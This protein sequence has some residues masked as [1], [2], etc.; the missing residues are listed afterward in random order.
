MSTDLLTT[1]LY[2]PTHQAT[3]ISRPRLS[4]RMNTAVQR[5]LTLIC[6]PA[7]F[8]KTTAVSEWI[9][10][11]KDAVAWVSLDEGDND[12]ARFLRYM[13]AALQTRSAGIGI[14]VVSLLRSPQPPSMESLLTRLLNDIASQPDELVL[15]LDDY[16]VI[17]AKQVERALTFLLEH[18]PPL[19]HL[20]ITT[21]EDPQLPLSRL[22]ARG[23]MTEI[24]ATDLRF[25]VAEAA[26]FLNTKMG[27]DLAE[28]DIAALEDR[29]EGWI[30]GLQLAAI[31]MQGHQDTAA[32][33][34]SFTGSHRFVMDYLIDEV[35]HRQQESVQNFLLDTSILD[36]LCGP[37]C[38]AVS[39]DSPGSGQ[40]I[41]DYIDGANLFL[42]PL[43]NDRRWYRYHHLFGELLRQRLLVR[44]ATSGGTGADHVAELHIRASRWFELN[45]LEIDALHHAIAAN[46]IA[47]AE[48]LIHGKGVPL[49]V[50]GGAAPVLSWLESLPPH[51]FANS[52]SMCLM[53]AGVLS[54]VGQV[55]RIESKLLAAEAAMQGRAETDG[56]SDLIG[57]IASMRSLVA[58]LSGD[59]HQIETVILQS[60]RALEH[61]DPS[62]TSARAA[63]TWQLGLAHLYQ[64]N[65]A[66]AR[67]AFDE[68]IA[69]SETSGNLHVN[70]LATTCLGNI[71]ETDTQ[72]RQASETYQQALRL[73]GQPPGPVACEAHVGLARIYYEWND[74]NVARQ[75]GLL[76]AQLARQTQIPNVVSSEVFLARLLLAQG[77]MDGAIDALA[78]TEQL[79]R[80]KNFWFRMP[81]VASMQVRALLRQG[82]IPDAARLAQMHDLPISLARVHLAQRDPLAALALLESV[83]Q[84]AEARDLRDERLTVIVLQLLAHQANG[85]AATAMHLLA[86]VM[87]L[88][89]PAGCVR[90][91][92]DEGLPMAQLVSAAANQGIDTEYASQ[93]LVAFAGEFPD[94]SLRPSL[95]DHG[96]SS[97]PID[98]LSPRELEVLHLI[99]EGY[100]NQEISDLLFVA[101]STVKGHNRV[102]FGKLDVQRRT[103]AVARA[104]SLGLL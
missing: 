93:L 94:S 80:R 61:L 60:R 6:A 81:D 76:S 75:H 64:K 37:L 72:L 24:R 39:G 26:E 28:S 50:R 87:A 68:A 45:N 36:K 84:Q 73:I 58:V 77:D 22:R 16:H 62:N 69:A 74:L 79:V 86:E 8:G 91:F 7:G 59:P 40:V 20:I 32:F 52:P 54:I 85:D 83:R 5:K 55:S 23:Q 33:I 56:T 102:I 99:S 47:R 27:L 48:R 3:V 90:L 42:V 34:Q 18:M 31:S 21:R 57:R 95:P 44:G 17:E 65:R 11:R 1:K 96:S 53:F 13:I 82:N 88:A 35:L 104:R 103:E 46:D 43:D 38:D 67:F 63:S 14:D 92:I 78:Q 30:A 97:S 15:I 98:T 4:D 49:Y 41:L 71:Q 66:E 51:V 19:L 12:P 29:A 2:I 89:A 70:I 100:S 25:T 10:E 9:R 101:L